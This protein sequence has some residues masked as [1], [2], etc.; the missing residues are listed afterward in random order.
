MREI[1]GGYMRRIGEREE[2]E[3]K[4][5]IIFKFTKA[6][7]KYKNKIYKLYKIKYNKDLI[8]FYASC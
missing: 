3:E 5:E 7:Q 1:K 6:N 4:D 8:L 2:E